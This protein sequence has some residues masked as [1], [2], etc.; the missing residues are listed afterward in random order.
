MSHIDDEWSPSIVPEAWKREGAD[1]LAEAVGFGHTPGPAGRLAQADDRPAYVWFPTAKTKESMSFNEAHAAASELS[2]VIRAAG[3]TSGALRED[4]TYTVGLVLKR[5][6]ALPIAELASFKAG[7][8]FVPCDPSWPP[9]RVT[10]ILEEANVCAI[11]RDKNS[12]A[13]SELVGRHTCAVVEVDERARVVSATPC[14]MEGADFERARASARKAAG[15]WSPPEVMYVMYTSGSTGKPKGCIVPTA[16]LYTHFQWAIDVQQLTPD[17]V[18]ITK[19][20]ATFD[21]SIHEMWVPL[22]L[23]CTSVVL[24]DGG[25]LDFETVH[26]TMARGKVTFAHFVPSVLALFLDFVSP[27]D[28]PCLRQIV[29]IGEALLLSHRAKL[30]KSFGRPVQLINMYGPTEASVVVTYFDALDDMPGLTHGFPIGFVPNEDVKIYV[31]DPEDPTRLMPQGDKGEICIAACR[32][33]T[34]I[35]DARSS[36]PKSLCQTRTVRLGSCTARAISGP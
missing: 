28:L 21:V 9:H 4:R 34:A 19:T 17:D 27:G 8:T 29:C 30:S 7:A 25:H 2:H 12:E 33:R 10:E 13:G 18:F 20:T 16:G 31:T 3:E 23:G 11:I 36:P 5:S 14:N 26:F 22:V 1:A 6:A 32:W 24:K 35:S 15:S